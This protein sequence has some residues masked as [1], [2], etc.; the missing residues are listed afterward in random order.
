MDSEI[1][2]DIDQKDPGDLNAIGLSALETRLKNAGLTVKRIIIRTHINRTMSYLD[3]KIPNGRSFRSIEIL[4]YREDVF[5]SIPLE[6]LRF[7]GD[8][9]AIIDTASGIVEARLVPTGRSMS[10]WSQ[11]VRQLIRLPGTEI[12]DK[13]PFADNAEGEELVEDGIGSSKNDDPERWRITLRRGETILELS[14]PSHTF[15]NVLGSRGVTVKVRGTTTSTEAEAL[16]LLETTVSAALFDLDLCYDI[17]VDLEQCRQQ[18]LRA[19]SSPRSKA[20]PSFPI[21]RYAPEALALY[22]YGRSA[23]GLPLLEFLAYYQVIEF[24]FPVFTRDQLIKKLRISLRDPR[25]DPNDDVA[26]G[27]IISHLQPRGRVTMSEKDQ[28]RVA[29]RAC[30]D[31]AFIEDF[32]TSS[33]EAKRHFC[34]KSPIKGVERLLLTAAA[35]DLPDQVADR[36]YGIRCRVVHTKQDGGG[37][38]VELLLPSSPEVQTLGPDI[39]LARVIAQQALIAGASPLT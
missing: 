25:F 29:V 26:L 22:R 10:S 1:P 37:P 13:K 39:D 6:T 11:L 3:V 27:R 24:F 36:I 16:G 7:L 21:N 8:F 38:G 18:P 33:E 35:Q 4:E 30:V 31:T 17:P 23:R 2:A 14:P 5:E 15:G 19:P 12:L 9:E 34:D 20:P 28:L 32:L